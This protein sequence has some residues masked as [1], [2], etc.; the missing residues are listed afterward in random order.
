MGTEILCGATTG[1]RRI[2]P[3]K[4]YYT[5]DSMIRLE[6]NLTTDNSKVMTV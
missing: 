6:V 2:P 1:I 5:D 4:V 3:V